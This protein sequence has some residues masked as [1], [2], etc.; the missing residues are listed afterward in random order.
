MADEATTPSPGRAELEA[1]D[2][3]LPL[4]ARL[5]EVL[6]ARIESGEWTPARPLPAETV[7]T[8]HYGVALGTMRRVL[9]ELV[10]QGMLERRHGSGTF[11]RRAKLDSSL[12]RFF[13]YGDS[14]TDAP[15]SR[16]LTFDQAA[17]PAEAAEALSEP[18][19]SPALHLHRLRLR[20][21]EPVLVEDIWLPLPRFAC[22]A[23]RHQDELGDLLY[24]E[25]ERECGVVIASAEEILTVGT[26]S[27]GDA[28]LLRCRRSDPVVFIER[29]ARTHD[30]TAVEW[31]RT[32]GKAADFRYRVEIR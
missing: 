31:R 22:L 15:A 13:R 19:G 27:A 30:G 9:G 8:A 12:F 14:R 3:R 29:T 17:L 5:R 26:A 28:L 20:D 32:A 23:Q 11:V 2:P 16:I 1:L 25:Y 10:E 4:H 21:D 7:L 6:V 18:V 24:P